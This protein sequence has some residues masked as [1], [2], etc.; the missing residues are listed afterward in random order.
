MAAQYLD[1]EDVPE[2]LQ[3]K[4]HQSLAFKTGSFV[5]RV[6]FN[7]P[8]NPATVNAANMYLTNEFGEVVKTN[9]RYDIANN[10][11]EVAPLEPFTEGLFYYLNITTK[12]RSKG[13]QRLKEPIKIK[14]KL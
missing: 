8:L 4:V 5:W 6:K 11:I 14:F 3:K 13:G 7:T 12:V 10:M 2:S 9:I 1:I